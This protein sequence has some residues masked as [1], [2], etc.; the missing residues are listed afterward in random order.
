MPFIVVSQSILQFEHSLN[1]KEKK[2]LEE[3]IAFFPKGSWNGV[4]IFNNGL[5]TVSISNDD[6]SNIS[7][8]YTRKPKLSLDEVID[9]SSSVWWSEYCIYY[10][11]NNE[12]IFE[13]RNT[14]GFGR[15]ENG[16]E[17]LFVERFRDKFLIK[18]EKNGKGLVLQRIFLNKNLIYEEINSQEIKENISKNIDAET[19]SILKEKR[20]KINKKAIFHPNKKE[21]NGVNNSGDGNMGKGKVFGGGILSTIENYRSKPTKDTLD[22]QLGMGEGYI[23]ID[24]IVNSEGEIIDIDDNSFKTTLVGFIKKTKREKLYEEIKRDLKYGPATG[25]DKSDKIATLRIIYYE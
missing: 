15:Y 25:N 19:E 12:M 2:F 16:N 22:Y 5:R 1:S 18:E 13:M 4:E 3:I 24:V 7:I 14:R 10:T 17:T 21:V 11:Y 6:T 20:Y 9:D 8:C 23:T